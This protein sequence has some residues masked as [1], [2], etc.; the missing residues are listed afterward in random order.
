MAHQDCR[1][2]SNPTRSVFVIGGGVWHATAIYYL[3][4]SGMAFLESPHGQEIIL[5]DTCKMG[6]PQRHPD[7]DTSPEL[8]D[9]T[10]SD[11]NFWRSQ[12]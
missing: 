5:C 10:R 12:Q 3:I 4:Q 8:N 7:D 6:W 11:T 2:C 9:L 1:R